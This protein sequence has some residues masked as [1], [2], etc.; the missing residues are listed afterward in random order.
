L[1][2]AVAIQYIHAGQQALPP[3]PEIQMAQ[4]L[5]PLHRL[6]LAPA[7][8]FIFILTICGLLKKNHH[9]EELYFKH[10]S[11]KTDCRKNGSKCRQIFVLIYPKEAFTIK[12]LALFNN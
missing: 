4:V 1:A 10:F 7:A 12:L 11:A 3:I 5:S 8:V 9:S 2:I 6:H